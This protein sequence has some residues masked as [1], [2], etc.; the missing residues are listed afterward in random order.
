MHKIVEANLTEGLMG[1]A[2]P[3][4]AQSNEHLREMEREAYEEG[5]L[6][7]RDWEDG[8]KTNTLTL[9]VMTEACQKGRKG[10]N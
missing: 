4:Y 2:G 3:G 7:F 6:C 9:K 5:N 8:I 10:T 1:E